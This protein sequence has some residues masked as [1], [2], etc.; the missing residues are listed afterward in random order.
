MALTHKYTLVDNVNIHYVESI[1]QPNNQSNKKSEL[2]TLVFLHG[3]PEYWGTWLNQLDYFAPNYRV[4]A[5]D[6]PGYN[7]SDKPTDTSF[8]TVPNLITFMTKFINIISPNQ[9]IILIAHDWG[10][11]IA[12]PL[13]AFNSH[14]ISKLII[15]NAAHPSTFT[16]EMI[17]N[18]IQREKS[19][20]I[21]DL[22]SDAG[23]LLLSK[24]NYEYLSE[25]MMVSKNPVIFSDEAK[26]SYRQVWSKKGAIKGMLQYYRAMPQLATNEKN[27]IP[28][29]NSNNLDDL[30]TKHNKTTSPVKNTSDIKIP[31]IRV[32]CP[33]LILWGEQDQAFVNEN[34]DDIKHYVP[35]CTLIRFPDTSHWLQH[36]KPDDVNNAIKTFITI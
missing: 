35:N 14:L 24:N 9:Q 5:P 10:G 7:L 18:P 11:A 29:D 36:E 2:T 34:L 12:W 19:A 21:H 8:Y 16:R 28:S 20:Y 32:D 23:E 27:L 22:I 1:N 3:F 30:D 31:N 15:L 4:I 25:K 26:V 13:A 6:L 33:T 17:N